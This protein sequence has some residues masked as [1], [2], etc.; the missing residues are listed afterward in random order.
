MILITMILFLF[1]AVVIIIS[2]DSDSKSQNTNT[3][4]N[5]NENTNTNSN[6][7]T[8]TTP[9]PAEVETNTYVEAFP[10]L[11][12]WTDCWSG[13]PWSST[14]KCFG[15]KVLAKGNDGSVS[16]SVY[17]RN[18]S[19]RTWP[20]MRGSTCVGVHAA[21]GQVPNPEVNCSTVTRVPTEY[22]C[23]DP[24]SKIRPPHRKIYTGWRNREHGRITRLGGHNINCHRDNQALQGFQLFR[25]PNWNAGTNRNPNQHHMRFGYRCGILHNASVENFNA[26]IPAF[27][28]NRRLSGDNQTRNNRGQA[29]H[30]PAINCPE[31]T[32][33]S[34]INHRESNSSDNDNITLSHRCKPYPSNNCTE[35][36]SR[37]NNNTHQ[38]KTYNSLIGIGAW[39]RD[40]E[41]MR[42]VRLDTSS[43]RRWRYTCC[44]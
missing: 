24:G 32:V 4:T 40:D 25:S 18:S 19:G 9:E 38:D 29:R 39:C 10:N 2:Q 30:H 7:D 36:S 31:N 5:T 43:G 22:V 20:I 8:E 28:F 44:K 6:S 23:Q 17:C 16:G 41:Y 26:S 1:S 15:D 14:Y 27:P 21:D 3:N 42:N 34:Q 11:K 33:I 12:N 13:T 35:R 37:I